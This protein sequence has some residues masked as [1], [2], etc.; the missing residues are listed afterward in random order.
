LFTLPS[1]LISRSLNIKG[2]GN[3]NKHRNNALGEKQSMLIIIEL[4]EDIDEAT[5]KNV[6]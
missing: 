6:Y 2:D 4:P 5:W 3:V 1:P